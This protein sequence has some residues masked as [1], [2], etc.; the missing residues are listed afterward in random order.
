MINY[1]IPHSYIGDKRISSR[2]IKIIEQ[3]SSFV[4]GG[5]PN[6]GVIWSQTKAIYRFFSNSRVRFAKILRLEQER[7][8]TYTAS[9]SSSSQILYHIQ[10]TTSLN[11]SDQK[12]RYELGCLN[13]ID[14]RGFLLHTSVLLDSE[15]V[16]QGIIEE[17]IYSRAESSL[18]S[19]SQD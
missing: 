19:S 3:L 14:H 17:D 2:F 4:G 10:D 9:V 15:K 8:L 6:C 1:S 7:M 12:G 13:Y 18:G 5:I 11:Y 16:M